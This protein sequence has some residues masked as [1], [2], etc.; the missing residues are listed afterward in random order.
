[1][2]NSPVEMSLN[3]KMKCQWECPYIV[4][5]RKDSGAYILANMSGKVFKDKVA[6]FRVIPYFAQHAIKSPEKLDE[7]LDQS[8]ENIKKLLDKSDN[9]NEDRVEKEIY[10]EE[11]LRSDS[12][13]DEDDAEDWWG[14]TLWP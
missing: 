6:A 10:D 1:M 14:D 2:R 11:P 7:V 9:E 5:A 12:K 8:P 3:R 13:Q 4:V